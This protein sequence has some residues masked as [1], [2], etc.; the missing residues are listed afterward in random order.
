VIAGVVGHEVH[1]DLDAALVCFAQQPLEVG[2]R[3]VLRIDRAVIGDV[4]TVVA[5]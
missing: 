1:D 3:A 2:H 4:V 5:G